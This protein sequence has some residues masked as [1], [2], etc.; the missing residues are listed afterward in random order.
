VPCFIDGSFRVW[1]K[2]KRFPRPRKVRLI[3]GT[4]RN[5]RNRGKEKNEICAIAAELRDA[6]NELRPK[7]GDR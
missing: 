6:V 4:F 7:N 1:P 3:V 5:Y 2:G